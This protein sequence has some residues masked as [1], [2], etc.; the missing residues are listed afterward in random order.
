ML[1]DELERL[2]D[3]LR[4]DGAVTAEGMPLLLSMLDGIKA[5]A[6]ALE[7]RAGLRAVAEVRA[8]AACIDFRAYRMRRLAAGAAA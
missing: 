7:V 8:P 4:G 6:R 2:A 1:S 5:D 3:V